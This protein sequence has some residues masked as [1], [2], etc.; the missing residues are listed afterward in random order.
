MRCV[1]VILSPRRDVDQ[2]AAVG[3]AESDAAND[4]RKEE[5]G[6]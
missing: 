5:N 1:A 2:I 4:I 6:L 3:T